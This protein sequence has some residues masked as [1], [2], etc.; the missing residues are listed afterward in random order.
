VTVSVVTIVRN[1]ARFLARAIESALDQTRPPAE[2]LVVDGRSIDDTAA[3][4]A[5]YGIALTQQPATGI[6]DARNHGIASTEGQLI[7]F[8]DHDDRWLPTKLERQ[9]EAFENSRAAGYCITMLRPAQADDRIAS[10]PVFAPQLAR[11]PIRGLTP[12]TLVLRRS[13]LARIGLFDPAFGVGCDTEW[14]VRAA[15]LGVA[16]TVVDEVLVEKLLHDRNVSIDTAANRREL[17]HI[18]RASVRRKQQLAR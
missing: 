5:R 16:L 9:I 1:G 6:A 12:S 10:H 4:A 17:L 14:F 11:G 7:A 18:A 15:D 3:I 8:L 13:V 2:I